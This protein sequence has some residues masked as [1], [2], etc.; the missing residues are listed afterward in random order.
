MQSSQK[1][2]WLDAGRSV[3]RPVLS[4]EQI[5]ANVAGIRATLEDL[6]SDRNGTG[7]APIIL[8]NLVRGLFC[9][10]CLRSTCMREAAMVCACPHR[11]GMACFDP[12]SPAR[13]CMLGGQAAEHPFPPLLLLGNDSCRSV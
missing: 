10:P 7:P 3:E 2:M 4:D 9:M 13:C 5:G 12:C 11:S 1:G 6:L 8:N